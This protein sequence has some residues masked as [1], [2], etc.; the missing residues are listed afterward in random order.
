MQGRVDI[1]TVTDS[2]GNTGKDFDGALA[3]GEPGTVHCRGRNIKVNGNNNVP[4]V[5]LSGGASAPKAPT[6]VPGKCIVVRG[7]KY[8]Q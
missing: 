5:G 8:C 2:K 6:A 1:G 7:T 3:A 4:Y